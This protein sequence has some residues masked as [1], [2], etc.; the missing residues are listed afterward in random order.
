M[1][2]KNNMEKK[3]EQALN[4]L[5]GIQPA[6]VQP[7]FYT[8]V[9]ARLEQTRGVWEN[10]SSFISRPVTMLATVGVVIVLNLAVLYGNRAAAARSASA[11]QF[12]QILNDAG[13]VA[14]NSNTTL[15]NIWSQENDQRVQK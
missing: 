6:T 13:D 8:R 5:D 12:E 2:Q 14:S 11:D 4:S 7:F 1:T 3:V 9:R 10:V 15:Y